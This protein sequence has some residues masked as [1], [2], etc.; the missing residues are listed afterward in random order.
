MFWFALGCVAL[1]LVPRVAEHRNTL[2]ALMGAVFLGGLARVISLLSAG[3]PEPFLTV[4]MVI[5]LVL[6]PVV[7]GAD[8]YSRRRAR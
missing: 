2:R 3:A 5:E 4:L 1:W 8:E 7:I 6:P